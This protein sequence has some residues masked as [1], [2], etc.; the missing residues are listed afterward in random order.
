MAVQ[1]A[2]GSIESAVHTLS[3]KLDVIMLTV[4]AKANKEQRCVRV[5]A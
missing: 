4:M 1:V 2:T 3:G 5:C